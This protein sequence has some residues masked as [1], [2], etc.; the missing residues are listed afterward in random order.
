MLV[1]DL[2]N[3]ITSGLETLIIGLIASGI[4]YGIGK[5]LEPL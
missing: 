5:L 4:S 1:I 3:R 2:L